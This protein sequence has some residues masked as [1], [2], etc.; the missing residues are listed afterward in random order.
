MTEWCG[1]FDGDANRC[2]DYPFCSI[3]DGSANRATFDRA[4]R[5][6]EDREAT[7]EDWIT[8]ACDCGG[9]GYGQ[10][11]ATCNAVRKG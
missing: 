2:S 6:T 3:H 10:H 1:G 8:Y 11:I 7:V 5:E 9:V 4:Y